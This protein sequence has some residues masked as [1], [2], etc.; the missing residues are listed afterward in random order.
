MIVGVGAQG[1]IDLYVTSTT[2]RIIFFFLL[3]AFGLAAGLSLLTFVGGSL[4]LR[5]RERVMDGIVPRHAADRHRADSLCSL[6]VSNAAIWTFAYFGATTVLFGLL[7]VQGEGVSPEKRVGA[8]ATF[9]NGVRRD[10]DRLFVW[11]FAPQIYSATRMEPASRFVSCSVVVGDHAHGAERRKSWDERNGAILMADLTATLPEF[12]V[13]AQL[14]TE[15]LS[16]QSIYALG[17][18]PQLAQFVRS[19]Y[20]LRHEVDGYRVYVR[21]DITRSSGFSR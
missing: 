1:A 11:G 12:F 20:R 13:D 18:Y 9:L 5:F 4:G 10:G 2:S 19:K 6:S 16:Q 17:R 14:R 3:L 8:L 7:C 15:F 21:K